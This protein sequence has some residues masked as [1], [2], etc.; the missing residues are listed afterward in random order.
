MDLR[1]YVRLLLRRWPVF[2]IAFVVVAGSIGAASFFVPAVYTTTASLSFS[3]A[4]ER[5]ATIEARRTGAGYIRERIPTYAQLVTTSTVLEPVI[6]SND[7]EESAASL[8]STISVSIPNDTAILTITAQGSSAEQAAT[9]ANDIAAQMPDAVA[10]IEDATSAAL[11]PVQVEV[12]QAALPPESRSAP[13]I[14][15]NLIVAVVIALF[16]AVFAAVIVDNFDTRVRRG[17]DVSA[18][19]LPYLGG[20]ETQ[21]GEASADLLTYSQ[22]DPD[23]RGYVRRIAIDLLFLSE[24]SP[25][26]IAFTSA[27]PWAGKTT[28][29]ANVAA[30]LTESGNRVVYIDA[31]MKGGRL[32]AQLR[33]PQLSGVTDV[34]TGKATLAE[35]RVDWVAGGFAVIPV[36]ASK[37]SAS[38]L[39]GSS[40]F[41][42]LLEKLAD[43]YDVVIVDAP[44]VTNTSEAARF[45]EHLES[46]VVVAEAAETRRADLARVA[47]SLTHA[48]RAVL[49]VILT[50]VAR[51]EESSSTTDR[52]HD[53]VGDLDEV[54]P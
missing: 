44:P 32:A 16:V 14:R 7:L 35:A 54:S 40:G 52:D 21:R 47:A 23:Y 49:G 3:T 20:L 29:A 15:L 30:A 41:G 8:A 6:A 2:V 46:I 28:V 39:L 31:D 33:L 17:K 43:D 27:L 10:A 22:L 48:G 51:G 19:G 18:L 5:D 42:E 34:V 13:N 26:R 36:G 24:K 38:D 37:M 45:T 50:R 9:I 25:A 4:T 11:S 12:V 1:S 53:S